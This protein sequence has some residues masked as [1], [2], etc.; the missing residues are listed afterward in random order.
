MQDQG[1]HQQRVSPKRS[2]RNG[3]VL[4]SILNLSVRKNSV[5]MRAGN[6]ANRA[7]FFFTIVQVNAD[8]EHLLEN[9]RRRPDMDDT[10][11]AR[12]GSP[13]LDV[14]F[15]ANRNHTVLMPADHPVRSC[16][17]V[18]E[19]PTS[20]EA[21]VSEHGCDRLSHFVRTCDGAHCLIGE[22]VTNSVP[23]SV[24]GCF[25]GLDGLFGY[26]A[27]NQGIPFC[28][29]LAQ[30]RIH[31]ESIAESNRSNSRFAARG[32]QCPGRASLRQNLC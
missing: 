19:G 31:V 26:T 27:A 24:E 1:P 30:G 25:Q 18:E 2:T 11:F 6:H 20:G 32:Q 13:A 9:R 10:G 4:R 15:L 16:T 5:S 28:F 22:K 21:L 14:E 7:V 8:G 12:P 29:D 3:A 17:L 23:I